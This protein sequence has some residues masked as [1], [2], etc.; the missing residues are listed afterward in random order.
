MSLEPEQYRFL[1]I[2]ED[3]DDIEYYGTFFDEPFGVSITSEFHY[4]Q[5][6]D[7]SMVL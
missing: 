6:D 7:C 3:T 1:R 4:E 2:G 5:L